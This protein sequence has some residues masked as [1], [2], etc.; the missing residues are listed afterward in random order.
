MTKCFVKSV[1]DFS[2]YD[3][4]WA[5]HAYKNIPYRMS[6]NGCGPTVAADIIASNPKFKR[7]TPDITRKWLI[8]H[9]YVINGSGTVHEGIPSV[10]KAYGFDVK[11]I[12]KM[13]DVFVEMAKRK[14][15][16]VFLMYG[17][18]PDGTVWTTGGHYVAV[19]GYKTVGKKHW[20][21]IC[22][23]GQRRHDGWYCYETS[24]KGCVMKVWTATVK[25]QHSNAWRFRKKLKQIA[26]YMNR[27]NFKYTA[28][29]SDCAKTWP[30]AKKKKKSNCAMLVNYALHK[31]L[32]WFA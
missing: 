10:L 22:D 4:R 20:F 7:I 16:A 6:T 27:H 28:A 29:S 8:D 23:P 9:N 13:T 14:R 3:T 5:T 11:F 25:V 21:Y 18:G 32:L 17:T 12:R 19:K 31:N 15:R 30:E 24:I 26:N 1:K 2:Q